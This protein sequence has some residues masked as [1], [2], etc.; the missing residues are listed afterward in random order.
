MTTPPQVGHD[1][2]PT[3]RASSRGYGWADRAGRQRHAGIGTREEVERHA[4]EEDRHGAAA[5]QPSGTGAE[6]HGSGTP[7]RHSGTPQRHGSGTAQ[8]H[9]DR[10]D[11]GVPDRH[12]IIVPVDDDRAGDD[13]DTVPRYRLIDDLRFVNE[14]VAS[15]RE[16]LRFAR[17]ASYNMAHI[18]LVRAFH[19]AFFWLFTAPILTAVLFLLWAFVVR[20]HRALT[21]AVLT[22]VIAPVVRTIPVIGWLIP[23]WLVVTTWSATTWQWAGGGLLVFAGGTAIAL[24]GER[25]R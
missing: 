10:A 25:R 19:I 23:E 9:D 13:E 22:L 12:Q 16:L 2:L 24:A 21:A 20:L 18:P 8:R 15:L 11:A 1:D 3:T 7:E 6:R 14:P 5:R 4:E 17:E